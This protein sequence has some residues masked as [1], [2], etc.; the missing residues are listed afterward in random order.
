MLGARLHPGLP[1]ALRPAAAEL[2]WQAF[3]AKLGPV[4]GPWPRAQRYLLRVMRADQVIIALG[5]QGQLL[6][7]AGF[8]TAEGGFAS[9]TPADLSA[10]YGLGGGL[11][12][13]TLLTLLARGGESRAF[14][15]DGLCVAAEARSQGLGSALIEA[16]CDEARLRGHDRLRLEV[17]ETNQRAVALYLR[18]GFRVT[19]RQSIGPLRL[20]FRF[21]AALT[22]ERKI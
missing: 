20:A 6:G 4:L 13:R 10:I 17:V 11:W 1:E 9:G 2:Y 8:R 3:G 16:I 21:R 15:L 12:R 14:L 7:I 19:A 22:M 5:P 18:L